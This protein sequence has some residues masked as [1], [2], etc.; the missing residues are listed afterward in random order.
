MSKVTLLYIKCHIPS[1]TESLN[2]SDSG[3]PT[4]VTVYAT[5]DVLALVNVS[6]VLPPANAA[7]K[8]LGAV[9][10]ALKAEHGVKIVFEPGPKL[11]WSSAML[12]SYTAHVS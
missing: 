11:A 9:I 2:G 6:D 10:V 3:V 7:L 12:T 1:V 5:N 4:S 8:R